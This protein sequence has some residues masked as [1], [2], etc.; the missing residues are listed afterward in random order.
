MKKFKIL[1]PCYNDW[2]SLFKLLNNI[3]N[4]VTMFDAEFTVLI[5][6]DCST[7]KMPKPSF[8]FK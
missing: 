8:S 5:V 6:N 1:I 3:D 4:N 2:Q 7:E